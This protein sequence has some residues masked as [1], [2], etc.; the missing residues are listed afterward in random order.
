L[1]FSSKILLPINLRIQKKIQV[2]ATNLV[3][4]EA[5]IIES[6]EKI[7]NKSEKLH[8]SCALLLLNG[9]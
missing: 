8:T 3:A 2:G 5:R 4:L 1:K 7:L 6:E 9:L